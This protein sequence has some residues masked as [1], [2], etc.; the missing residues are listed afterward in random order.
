MKCNLWVSW[1]RGGGGEEEGEGRGPYV[2]KRGR[3]RARAL[4]SACLG[5]SC[6]CACACACACVR[7]SGVCGG[8]RGW[9][10]GCVCQRQGAL[11]VRQCC[12]ACC[13]RGW[14]AGS[15]G[16]LGRACGPPPV[17]LGVAP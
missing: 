6:V 7:A 14:Q 3:A 16:K 11:W 9:G 13:R 8:V 10:G 15:A 12:A 4:A 1:V 5:V 2:C 17:C